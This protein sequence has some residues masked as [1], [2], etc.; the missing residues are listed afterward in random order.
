MTD[1]NDKEQ[2]TEEPTGKRLSDAR[3]EGNLAVSREM[4]A[5]FLF[6][7]ILVVLIWFGPYMAQSAT[8]TLRI[9]IERPEQISLQDGGLQ[10]VLAHVA[11][12]SGLAMVLVFGLLL[13]VAVLGTMI[14]TGFYVGT[15]KLKFDPK[16]LLLYQ[17]YKQIFSMNAIS[18]LIK[19]FF[20]MVVLGYVTYRVLWPLM[21]DFPRL[22]NVSL[23]S[24]LEFLHSK[25]VRLVI[26]MMLVITV[27]AIADILYVRYQYF[28][29]LRM[30]KQEVKDEYKQTEGDP[31]IRG[32]LRQIR[33]EKARK[34]M[35]MKV[36]NASV[37]V[38]NPTHFAVAL[39]YDGTKM[40]APVVTAKGADKVAARIRE[41][42]Q[43]HEVPIVSNPP[44]ARALFD[45]V[46][47]DEPI[48]PE[49]YRAVA[50]VISYVYKLKGKLAG[51]K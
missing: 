5:W 42:A 49:H 37:V 31:M 3:T 44:L 11:A 19:S 21:D 12:E 47:L 29:G 51:K 13:V 34:R 24:M 20:K 18:E 33:L 6:V 30:T 46:E 50:E 7:G 22:V 48:E 17:G 25:T 45:T 40:A 10:K 26:I 35:M 8:A 28:K 39:E 27:I 32:R 38:T 4:S 36:P 9:F 23:P 41:V 16:K 1:S 2:K 15:G 14:Q 43:E